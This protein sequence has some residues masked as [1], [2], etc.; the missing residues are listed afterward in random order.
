MDIVN[1]KD[2]VIGKVSEIDSDHMEKKIRRAVAIFVFDKEGRLYLQKR[3]SKK[4]RYPLYWCCSAAGLVDSGETY[5]KAALR[6]LEEELGLKKEQ[7]DL[8]PLFK[9]MVVTDLTEYIKTY[10]LACNGEIKLNPEE[11]AAGKFVSLMEVRKMMIRGEKFTP[12]FSHL[13]EKV[14]EEDKKKAR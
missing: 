9:K 6:E 1:R 12:T 2:K 3:S 7:A 8:E 11:V 10:A 5:E 4:P 14:F 13:F